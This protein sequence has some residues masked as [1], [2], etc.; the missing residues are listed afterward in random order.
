MAH[1]HDKFDFT[2][3]GFVLH[4]TEPRIVL[5]LHK[6]LDSWLQPGGHIELN[7]DPLQAL[8][9]ELEEESGLKPDDYTIIQPTEQPQTTGTSIVLPLP[10]HFSNHAYNETHRHLD[11]GYLIQSNTTILTSNPDGA[12]DIGWF[13]LSDIRQK[14]AEGMMFID[15]LEICE[16]IL[17][18]LPIS[19]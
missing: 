7:E 6:K 11:L 16:W 8:H 14:H 17:K 9:H 13:N 4:P 10:F 18:R 5:L 19:K 3:S 15:T 1:I 2:V 12:S